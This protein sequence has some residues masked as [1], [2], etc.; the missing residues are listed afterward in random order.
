VDAGPGSARGADDAAGNAKEADS[1]R[2][3]LSPG[4]KPFPGP[5]QRMG[6]DHWF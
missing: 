3:W 1:Q 5:G 4:V 6:Y 2:Q